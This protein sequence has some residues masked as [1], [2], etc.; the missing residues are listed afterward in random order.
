MAFVYFFMLHHVS[1]RKETSLLKFY[2]KEFCSQTWHTFESLKIIKRYFRDYIA[3]RRKMLDRRLLHYSNAN[4]FTAVKISVYRTCITWYTYW[5][6]EIKN[7]MF[8]EGIVE[9]LP[10]TALTLL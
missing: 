7:V 10:V 4:Y 6:H 8:V 9:V 1:H 3:S 2:S 5:K